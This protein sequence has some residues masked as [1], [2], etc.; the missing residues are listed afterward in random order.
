MRKHYNI[1]PKIVIDGV[2]F[3]LYQTGIARVWTSLLQTWAGDGFAMHLVVLDR[4]YSVPK[5][6][7]VRYRAME[8]FDYSRTENDRRVLQ[9]ICDEESASVFISTYYTTP[10]A[11]P[12]VFMAYDMIPELFGWD[13]SHPMWREKHAAVRHAPAFVSI[14]QQTKTDLKQF[15]PEIA[16]D[17]ITVTP[18]ACAE[19]FRPRPKDETDAFRQ[20]TATRKPYFLTV[21]AREIQEYG[22]L[23]QGAGAVFAA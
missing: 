8:L 20:A 16:A 6:P 22:S 13:L 15:F 17:D 1:H 14:S 4:G 12:S 10:M 7:G 21:G 5:I 11:T 2:F 19:V 3:Q 23:F 18:L 9:M